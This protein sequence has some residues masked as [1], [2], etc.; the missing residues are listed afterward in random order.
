MTGTVPAQDDHRTRV[1]RA[2]REK[3]RA[4]LIEAATL[5][6]AE[7]GPEAAQIDHVIRQAGM[8]RGTFY[9]YFR[10]TDELLHAAKDAL[11]AEMVALVSAASDPAAA[12]AKRLADGIKTFVDLVQRHPLL[13]DFTGRLGLRNLGTGWLVP[14]LAQA[15]LT[16]VIAD[17]VAGHL[18]L[19]MAGDILEAST[20]ALLLRLM[21]GETV[22][23]AGF[24][25]AMLRM[26]GYPAAEAI[27]IAERPLIPLVVPRDSLIIRSETAR[28]RAARPPV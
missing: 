8:S 28:R 25:S 27:R 3:T 26:L 21:A 15:D 20:L 18:T 19:R 23:V 24:V 10:S 11:A 16:M 7:L 5:V 1:G 4:R 2:R 17:D 9:N 14:T 22:D 13:L 12:P 6:F